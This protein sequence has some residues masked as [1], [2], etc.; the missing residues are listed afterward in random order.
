MVRSIL[1]ICTKE[2]LEEED[3][4]LG[5]SCETPEERVERKRVIKSKILVVGRVSRILALLRC[6]FCLKSNPWIALTIKR[7]ESERVS[8]LKSVAGME[9]LPTDS[10]ANGAKGIK[11][12]IKNF[13]EA[14]VEATSQV[15]KVY[16]S[17]PIAENRISRT[18]VCHQNCRDWQQGRAMS[19]N[20]PSPFEETPSP[21]PP[22]GV[23][24]ALERV[25]ASVGGS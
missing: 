7:S 10:L 1:D 24:A 25:I 20:P 14:Y 3:E 13:E 6:A 8:E 11:D 18:S 5:D 15:V 12:M 16:L 2:E 21:V 22:K 23:S 17:Y 4:G 9:E 19:S